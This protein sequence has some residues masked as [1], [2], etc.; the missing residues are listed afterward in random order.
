MNK[1]YAVDVTKQQ[2]TFAAAH[3]ITFA[4]GICERIHGHN[5]GVSCRVEGELD[6]NQYVVD[7]IALRDGLAKISQELDH[8][9][10]LADSHPTIK[11]QS[12]ETEVVATFEKKRWVFPKEDCVLLPVSN[13]TA[14]LIASYFVDRLIPE[15]KDH[16]HPGIRQLTVRIDENQGQWGECTVKF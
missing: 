3:F 6:E 5:Y 7:F 4:G 1:T 8:H 13:T 11:V 9:V 12:N 10:I 2:L 15:M 16:L 14:E